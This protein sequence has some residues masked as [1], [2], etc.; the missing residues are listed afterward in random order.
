VVIQSGRSFGKER[1]E[2]FA[3]YD[4]ADALGF[5]VEAVA[6]PDALPEPSFRL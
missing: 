6:P 3:D 2:S 5:V 4:T 1:D